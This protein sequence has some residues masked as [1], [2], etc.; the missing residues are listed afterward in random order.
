MRFNMLKNA[1]K[2]TKQDKYHTDDAQFSKT[3]V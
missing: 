3:H 1:Y 2:N